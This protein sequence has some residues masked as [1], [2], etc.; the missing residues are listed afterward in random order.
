MKNKLVD[1]FKI[2]YPIV[3][4]GMIW[5]SGYKL[6][7]AVSNAGGLG[8]IGAGSMY[9]EVLREHIQKCKKATDKPFGVNVPML[10]PNIEEIMNIIVEEGV[11]IVFTSAGNPKTWTPFL[12]Q[13]GITV[14]HVVSSSKFALKAQEAGVDAIVAEGFEAGGHNGREETTT[15]TLI[16]MVREKITVPLIAAGGI[17]TGRGMLAAM[18]L[19]ADGVQMGT[20][21]IASKESSA[22][23]NFKNLLLDVQE[24]DTV[25]TLKELAPVRLIKNEFYTGL[26]A[27]YAKNPSVEDLKE[28]LG[29]ARAKKGMF[30]G[31][32]VEGELEVGQIS[33]LIHKIEPVSDIIKNII[34]EFDQAKR[35]IAQL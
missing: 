17:A 16:P 5:N 28:Y 35:D 4:G 34:A 1:L 27:L 22:H 19:G 15:L 6:A 7:S 18:V 29:R 3:Q 10:Y 31:D 25:L 33:G 11:K 20:R 30:E 9:P 26:Q 23:D 8:L 13:H 21:F 32:L 2:Q 12:K 24:G 14:V